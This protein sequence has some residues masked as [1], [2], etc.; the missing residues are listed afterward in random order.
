MCVGIEEPKLD[1][2]LEHAVAIE[3]EESSGGSTRRAIK[4]DDKGWITLVSKGLA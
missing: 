4:G 3:A 2:L 1:L